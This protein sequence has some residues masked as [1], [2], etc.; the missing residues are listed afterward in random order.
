MKYIRI[1]P[2][3][4]S[5]VAA[6]FPYHKELIN[7]VKILPKQARSYDPERKEWIIDIADPIILEKLRRFCQDA[8]DE[9]TDCTFID[10]TILPEA[11]AKALE[12]K[13]DE[14]EKEAAI[15][16]FIE[17][18]KSLPPYSLKLVRWAG[19]RLWFQMKWLGEEF[20]DSFHSLKKASF[21]S[22]KRG[23]V[24]SLD[25]KMDSGFIFEVVADQRIIDALVEV[26]VEF[27]SIHK[28]DEWVLVRDSLFHCKKGEK[29]YIAVKHQAIDLSDLTFRH[30]LFEISK[31]DGNICW[32]CETLKYVTSW[33]KE[34]NYAKTSI[35]G[36]IGFFIPVESGLPGILRDLK[37][38][39]WFCNWAKQILDSP[40]VEPRGTRYSWHTWSAHE[41]SHDADILIEYLKKFP[42]SDIKNLI[43]IDFYNAK[44]N[45]INQLKTNAAESKNAEKIA[46]IK[47]IAEEYLYWKY[48]SKQKLIEY[49]EKQGLKPKKSWTK[50]KIINLL[51][52]DKLKCFELLEQNRSN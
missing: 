5:K 25:Q 43:G 50:E 51:T 42:E 34:P 22:W 21:K 23:L 49:A 52:E 46:N 39:E 18:M 41:F 26:K 20:S 37:L 32:V 4:D 44:A 15:Q 24:T 28:F 16:L 31:V 40:S 27:V 6:T 29:D 36:F 35:G 48:S 13:I 8:A 9:M 12:A 14:E 30:D 17:T 3:C 47:N 2:L 1:I 33:L 10:Q 7:N 11:K 45:Q 38:E 19:D